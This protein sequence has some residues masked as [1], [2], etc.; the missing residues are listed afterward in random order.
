MLRQLGEL[1]ILLP[2]N[3][4]LMTVPSIEGQAE[5]RAATTA[6]NSHRSQEEK[7]GR[8]KRRR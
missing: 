6:Y 3:G 8:S 7:T 4:R 5:V 2:I 1:R